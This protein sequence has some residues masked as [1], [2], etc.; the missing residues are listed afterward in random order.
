VVVAW[1]Q[2][3]VSVETVVLAALAQQR[4]LLLLM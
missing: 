3:V 4:L 2:E 1:A